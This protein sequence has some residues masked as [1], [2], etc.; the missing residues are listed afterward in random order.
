MLRNAQRTEENLFISM[1]CS[2]G[3]ALGTGRNVI[4]RG[5]KDCDTGDAHPAIRVYA[6]LH[7]RKRMNGNVLTNCLLPAVC[8]STDVQCDP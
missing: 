5:T 3:T 6:L 4:I 1:A 8:I 2:V 7:V